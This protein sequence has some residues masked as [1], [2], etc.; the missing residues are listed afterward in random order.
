M[1][2]QAVEKYL[3][4]DTSGDGLSGKPLEQKFGIQVE[5][6]DQ[7]VTSVA[8]GIALCI[9]RKRSEEALDASEIKYRSVV[10]RVKEV[11]FQ[12]DKSGCWSFLNPAWT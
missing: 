1:A 7:E 10:D 9:E 5:L 6:M 8:H 12:L 2:P 11:I 3:Q 4:R